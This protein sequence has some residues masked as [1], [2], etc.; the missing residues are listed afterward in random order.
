[1]HLPS[2]TC[3]SG[4]S[5]FSHSGADSMCPCKLGCAFLLNAKAPIYVDTYSCHPKIRRHENRAAAVAGPTRGLIRR[6]ER[7][8]ALHRSCTHPNSAPRSCSPS[9]P[10]LH[11]HSRHFS[12]VVRAG[13]RGV[14]KAPRLLERAGAE[15]AQAAA[16]GPP[17]LLLMPWRGGG[18]GW[19]SHQR[20]WGSSQGGRRTKMGEAG[21]GL[22]AGSEC[23]SKGSSRWGVVQ[24]SST[25]GRSPVLV[26]VMG[27]Y[28]SCRWSPV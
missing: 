15:G 6:P 8:L 23:A 22:R 11:R 9:S 24:S 5:A 13:G 25:A 4:P 2:S 1:M 18:C 3:C 27:A 7:N 28:M 16:V 26:A 19:Q 14:A 20:E 10:R 12:T 17:H 21:G